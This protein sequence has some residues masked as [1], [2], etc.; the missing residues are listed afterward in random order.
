MNAAPHGAYGWVG[1]SVERQPDSAGSRDT[2]P[3]G[4]AM[5]GVCSIRG[6]RSRTAQ[7]VPD[8]DQDRFIETETIR[9][10]HRFDSR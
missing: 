10:E 1:K 8:S 2:R 5:P 3:G 6:W 9:F 7:R 4:K